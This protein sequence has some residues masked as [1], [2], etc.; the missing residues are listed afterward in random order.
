LAAE[1]KIKSFTI[2]ANTEKIIEEYVVQK[3][4]TLSEI[5]DKYNV[6][7]QDLSM[8]N[9]LG[10]QTIYIGQK[11]L[12][13]LNP[14]NK[15]S[16]DNEKKEVVQEIIRQGNINRNQ[17]QYEKAIELYRESLDF[18]QYNM[19]AY[20]GIGYSNLK[21]GLHNT[22]IESFIKAVKI[23]PYDPKSHYNLGLAYVLIKEKG[24]AFEQYKILKI[25][26]EKYATRL[27]MYI[28]SLR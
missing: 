26:N 25:L 12:I 9:K 6:S 11:L 28:D 23:D 20:Y 8:Y 27:L 15:G 21:M 1:L 10:G 24:P 3:G 14:T 17:Q 7:I 5:G 13:P 18:D 22:A 4:D 16:I 19:D 2:N